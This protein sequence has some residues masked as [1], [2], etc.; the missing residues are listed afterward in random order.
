MIIE[1][2]DDGT[3]KLTIKVAKSEDVGAYKCEA[4]NKAGK[5]KTEAK[6]QV[7]QATVTEIAPTETAPEFVRPLAASEIVEGETVALEC[8]LKPGVDGGRPEVQ[9]TKDGK[10]VK[11]DGAHMIVESLDDGT[12]RLTIQ[13]ATSQDIGAYKCEA[14]NTA[15]KAKTEAKLQV[16]QAVVKEVKEE[17]APEF[18]K[19]LTQGEIIEG[20]TVEFECTLKVSEGA[21]PEVHWMKDGKEVKPDG[22]HMIVESRDDGTQ[23]L[24]IQKA[25]SEDI[26]QYKC[27][28]VNKAGTAKTEAKLNIKFAQQSALAAEQTAPEFVQLLE[29]AQISIG[30]DATLECAVEGASAPEIRWLKDGKPVKADAKHVIESKPDGTQRLLIKQATAADM[31]QYVCEAVNSAGKATTDAAIEQKGLKEFYFF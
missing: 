3:Q 25:K 27:E 9:W 23:R 28:A 19:P 24:I 22:A 11:S 7:K 16:K 26:G 4:V 30:A 15:G 1:S 31:G 17:T 10:P 12:Q 14:T 18:V 8:A 5:A 13:K 6:L 2:R 29:S 20:Q 21:K